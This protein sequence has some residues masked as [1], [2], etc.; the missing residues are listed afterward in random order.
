[1]PLPVI[2]RFVQKYTLQVLFASLFFF[3]NSANAQTIPKTFPETPE[4][5]TEDFCR[6]EKGN[7]IQYSKKLGASE[8]VELLANQSIDLVGDFN[9]Y[10]GTSFDARI[11]NAIAETDVYAMPEYGVG[12][13][14]LDY[15]GKVIRTILNLELTSNA[16]GEY[17]LKDLAY[18]T[19]LI[20]FDTKGDI[21]RY[22]IGFSNK[23]E[24]AAT[25][26][27][28]DQMRDG[29][30][31][32]AYKGREITVTA[33]LTDNV[34]EWIAANPVQQT[35]FIPHPTYEPNKKVGNVTY[36]YAPETRFFKPTH[37]PYYE[38]YGKRLNLSKGEMFATLA[39]SFE[40]NTKPSWYKLNVSGNRSPEF[41]TSIRFMMDHFVDFIKSDGVKHPLAY[42]NGPDGKLDVA[43]WER[44]YDA[45]F[46]ANG[47]DPIVFRSA[48]LEA[49]AATYSR[50]FGNAYKTVFINN[51]I[52]NYWEKGGYKGQQFMTW[53]RDAYQQHHETTGNNVLPWFR[54]IYRH[55]SNVSDIG[56]AEPLEVIEGTQRDLTFESGG[57]FEKFKNWQGRYGTMSA[58]NALEWGAN[59]NDF[60]SYVTNL[61]DFH[62]VY[63]FIYYGLLYQQH[64]IPKKPIFVLWHDVEPLNYQ[65]RQTN[66]WV[67]FNDRV[68]RISSKQIVGPEIMF[69]TGAAIAFFTP[70]SAE[71]G[72]MVW[73][74]AVWSE[75]EDATALYPYFDVMEVKREG[76]VPKTFNSAQ[77]LYPVKPVTFVNQA[78]DAF[79]IVKDH[80]EILENS[81]ALIADVKMNS[82]WVT[83]IDKNPY[84]AAYFRRPFVAYREYNGELL[85]FAYAWYNHSSINT[86]FRTENGQEYTIELNGCYPTIAK[87]TM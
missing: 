78:F 9:T 40:E 32:T 74:E 43:A 48:V 17:F 83:N 57:D 34:S 50:F 2:P 13:V 7:N 19:R 11:G 82:D 21:K 8:C 1:M 38:A 69:A 24:R 18:K 52:W 31:V 49:F 85:V 87:I 14:E 3:V 75:K 60:G 61:F 84:A 47:S 68:Y 80:K 86:T 59:T 81:K 30:N 20:S 28:V 71:G 35:I 29:I 27:S 15:S 63:D 25:S 65:F 70:T 42:Q 77:T 54:R 67:Q 58:A 37:V 36:Y 10:S 16:E 56:F 4:I 62:Y 79:S 53:V 44:W 64:K 51:E 6:E 46:V 33:Y 55:N 45:A 72:L 22:L 12:Y 26:F 23:Y 5:V 66:K 41:E 73:S 39:T 76:E